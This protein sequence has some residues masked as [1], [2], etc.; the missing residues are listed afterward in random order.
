MPRRRRC[1]AATCARLTGC[2]GG[3][4]PRRETASVQ[5]AIP[6]AATSGT[7]RTALGLHPVAQPPIA[8]PAVPPTSA[9][10]MIAPKTVPVSLGKRSP[11]TPSAVGKTADIPRPS[12]A[13]PE[14]MPPK[15]PLSRTTAVPAMVIAQDRYS[16]L[17]LPRRR[18]ASAASRRPPP[19]A[20]LKL[21]SARSARPVARCS[22]SCIALPAQTNRQFSL[23]DSK[24]S[25][26]PISQTTGWFS[27]RTKLRTGVAACAARGNRSVR[28]ST[29]TAAG[30]AAN[31]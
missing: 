6:M 5:A 30:A 20:T 21:T 22:V 18:S 10:V 7:I 23:P 27:T 3:L 9:T 12:T 4:P 8:G 15:P 11:A 25:S 13:K 24:N 31:T 29:N 19:N 1:W 16:R 26:N 17:R 14:I 28:I 2:R